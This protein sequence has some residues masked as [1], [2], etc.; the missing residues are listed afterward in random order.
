MSAET[1]K[2][3][4]GIDLIDNPNEMLIDSQ[5][6]LTSNL[7]KISDDLNSIFMDYILDDSLS[8]ILKQPITLF[9]DIMLLDINNNP[10]RSIREDTDYTLDGFIL[11]LKPNVTSIQ[12]VY[13]LRV[14]NLSSHK[15][16]T[17]VKYNKM[18]SL[19]INLF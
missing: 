2:T 14:L 3:S 12:G 8:V 11:T 9:S 17:Q 16:S 13:K 7:Q 6:K 19:G 18:N 1:N 15:L 5:K 4:R 10:I